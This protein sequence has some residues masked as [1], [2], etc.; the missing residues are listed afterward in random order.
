MIVMHAADP[1]KAAGAVPILRTYASN[2]QGRSLPLPRTQTVEFAAIPQAITLERRISPILQEDDIAHGMS[3][4][5][6]ELF[7]TYQ[8]RKPLGM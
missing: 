3:H 1:R 6:R 2:R 8:L 4:T 7:Y 5:R